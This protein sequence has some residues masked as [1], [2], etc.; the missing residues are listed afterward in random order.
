MVTC[1]SC[2]KEVPDGSAFCPSCG[3]RISDDTVTGDST[4]SSSS[5][6]RGDFAA[7]TVLAGRYHIVSLAGRG[8]MGE[9]YEAD[10]LTLGQVVALKFLPQRLAD[11]D[12]GEENGV[13]GWVP[14]DYPSAHEECLRCRKKR[15]A[16]G[17]SFLGRS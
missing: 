1:I 8:G 5:V 17:S 3:Q 2:A 13:H 16:Q 15:S 14:L 10:D 6:D 9:V 7:G 4:H 12:D 11:E